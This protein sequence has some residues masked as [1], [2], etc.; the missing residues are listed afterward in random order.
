[1]ERLELSGTQVKGQAEKIASTGRT[2]CAILTSCAN[3]RLG[4]P[5]VLLNLSRIKL[6]DAVEILVCQ[7]RLVKRTEKRKAVFLGELGQ[8]RKYLPAEIGIERSYGFVREQQQR[9]LNQS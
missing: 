1:M 8:E 3:F 2:R 4:R 9:M 5:N 6:N 7:M